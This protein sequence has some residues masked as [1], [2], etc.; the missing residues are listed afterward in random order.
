[1]SQ[2]WKTIRVFI[3]STFKDMHS[4]R[5]HL[6]NGVFVELR[7]WCAKNDD[8]I[9]L[10]LICVGREPRGREAGQGVRN[11]L[12]EIR[13]CRPFFYRFAGRAINVVGLRRNTM[14]LMNRDTI[15]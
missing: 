7:D 5:D 14:S 3:S 1:M 9:W 6:I 8:F 10:T 11:C 4:E 15:G 13:R 12:D 2:I